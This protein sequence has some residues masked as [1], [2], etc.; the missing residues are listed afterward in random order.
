MACRRL[1]SPG[2]TTLRILGAAL[3][4]L[5]LA[6]TALAAP[7]EP[8]K[9]VLVLYSTRRDARI[10]VVGE[11]ELPRM[12]DRGLQT[13]LDY[14]TEY[15]DRARFPEPEY[16]A[17]LRDF[18][19]LKYKD[20]RFDVIVAMS[21]IALEFLAQSR[22]DLFGGS[23]VVFFSSTHKAPLFPNSTGIQSSVNYTGTVLLASRLQ[24][25]LKHVFV[26]SGA[27]EDDKAFERG[28]RSQLQ[29]YES[30][31]DIQYLSGL[32]TPDLDKRLSALPADSMVYYTVVDRD[33]AGRLYHPLDYLDHVTSVANAP[34]YSWVDSGMD[35]GIVGGSLKQQAAQVD[36]VGEIALR[37]LHG[38]SAGSIPV[39]TRDLN[40]DQVDWR[41]LR[42]WRISESLVPSGTVIRFRE[43]S[44]W[45]RYKDYFLA[46]AVVIL[47][48]TALIAGLL[49]QRSRRRRAESQL[50]GSEAQLRSS[51]DRIRDLGA[52]LLNA[53]ETERSR[54]ARELHDD[55]SQQI[56]LLAIDLELLQKPGSRPAH[57][58]AGAALAR[59][60]GIARSVHDISHR[61]HPA[62]LRLI[63]LVTA[64]QSLQRE[65]TRA[66]LVITFTHDD[67]PAVFSA[68]LTLCVFRVVQEALQ[69]AIKYSGAGHVRVNLSGGPG[70][71]ALT[72]ADDGAGF[73]VESAWGKGLGL[74]SMRERLEAIG[75]VFDIVSTPGAGTRIDIVV[76]LESAEKKIA[77]V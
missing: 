43:P 42:R 58:L 3:V 33:G 68:D 51:Y 11:R 72:I 10:A 20:V 12:L 45:D 23:P 64:L 18:L 46:A 22:A 49:I 69:N 17:A 28:A 57:G 54:I 35:H 41:Q 27:G 52:R 59:V 8:Q 25:G 36:A 47:G 26:V 31:F 30:K 24:P 34:V 53:Q 63:G 75:G 48:Q 32:T 40:A 7:A 76:P 39:S 16:R 61:L 6:G 37:I 74:I 15:I 56:A 65:L 1:R 4:L 38:E 73:V 2:H 71:L 14:Y 66:D 44:A 62:K 55:I 13:R 9:Q 77:A 60:E 67:V 19:N 50:R 70:C 5:E 29:T 21:D